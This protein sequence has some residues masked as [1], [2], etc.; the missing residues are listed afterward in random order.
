M[1]GLDRGAAFQDT[2]RGQLGVER[3]PFPGCLPTMNVG[4][5]SAIGLFSIGSLIRNA[6]PSVASKVTPGTII[7]CA[8]HCSD[9]QLAASG[10]A[11]IEM[12]GER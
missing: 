6:R 8:I 11:A 9:V 2:F 4:L 7:D 5:I 10:L 3:W 1:G 12:C